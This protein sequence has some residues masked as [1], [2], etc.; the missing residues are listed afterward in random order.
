VPAG[1]PVRRTTLD[2]PLSLVLQLLDNARQ[3]ARLTKAKYRRNF[4]AAFLEMHPSQLKVHITTHIVPS[5]LG[6]L[7]VAHH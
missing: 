5:R 3:W 2:R 6:G 4:S 1:F 7:V